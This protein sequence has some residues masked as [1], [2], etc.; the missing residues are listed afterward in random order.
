MHAGGR[1]QHDRRTEPV[2]RQRARGGIRPE[3]RIG[4]RVAAHELVVRA[5]H[6]ER[7]RPGRR[8]LQVVIDNGAF[9]RVRRRRLVGWQRRVGV[10]VPPHAPR[11]R[12]LEQHD[13]AV[14]CLRIDL[15]ERRD[16]VENPAPAPVCADDEVVVFDDE[17]AD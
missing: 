3:H 4:A 8:R 14:G 5:E 17:I 2:E 6:F 13:I 7:D 1:R 16:V 10:R 15:T 12:W 9:R 11:G